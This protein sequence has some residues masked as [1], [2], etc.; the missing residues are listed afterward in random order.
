MADDLDENAEL[1]PEMDIE[2]VTSDVDEAAPDEGVSEVDPD[3]IA[4]ETVDG[5]EYVS[6]DELRK[7]YMRQADYTKKNQAR[8]E[9]E[10]KYD[11]YIRVGE[12]LSND[13]EGTLRMLNAQM[14][15]NVA[16]N[17]SAEDEY[18]SDEEKV[19]KQTQAEI[20]ELRM[21][22]E[23]SEQQ[24]Q[25]ESEL[26]QL[27]AAVG[28]VDRDAVLQHAADT[29]IMNLRAAYADMNFDLITKGKSSSASEAAKQ[30]VLQEKREKAPMVSRGGQAQAA[31]SGKDV[32][33]P[34][35]DI[36]E[37]IALA[38]EGKEVSWQGPSWAKRV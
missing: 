30:Q 18:M 24:R 14:G 21:A 10:R 27:E 9:K 20:E 1:N 5:T 25:I 37:A 31:G 28:K 23:R 35:S 16:D 11:S 22:Y 17:S 4:V 34:P 19:L 29:G 12:A 15:W 3:L 32:V 7:G 36:R 33:E 2:G 6:V 38:M 26:A 13:P 8:A